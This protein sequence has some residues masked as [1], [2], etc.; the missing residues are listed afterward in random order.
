MSE[1]NHPMYNK[2]ELLCDCI[3]STGGD[4]KAAP[5][6]FNY[7]VKYKAKF[8]S[9]SMRNQDPENCIFS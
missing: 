9:G 5:S 2:R 4:S 6:T 3:I 7:P 8:T 1:E